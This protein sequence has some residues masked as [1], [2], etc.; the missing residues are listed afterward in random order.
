MCLL[1][2]WDR[3]R[4]APPVKDSVFKKLN[5]NLIEPADLCQRQRNMLSDTIRLQSMRTDKLLETEGRS[6]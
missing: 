3:T 5:L 4:T 6:L 2:C 1:M